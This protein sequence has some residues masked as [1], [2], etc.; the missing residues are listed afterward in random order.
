MTIH[1]GIDWSHQKHDVVIANE[2]GA[3]LSR[4]TIEHGAAGF[5]KL[6][7][8][9]ASLGV[10]AADCLVGIESSNNILL[11]FLQTHDYRQVYVVPPHLTAASRGRT[12]VN[13]AHTDQS[14]GQLI[15]ELLRTD[16]HRLQLWR[17]DS[18]LIQQIRHQVQWQHQ[19][20]QD[21]V[22]QENRLRDLLRRYYPAALNLFSDLTRQIT[23][24]FLVQYPDPQEAAALDYDAFA[25]FARKQGYPSP[26]SLPKQYARFQQPV[27]QATT[28]TILIHQTHGQAL[29]A[30]LLHLVKQRA[31]SQR[32]LTQLF[33]QHADASIFSSFPGLGPW[34]A[35]ALLSKF[36]DNRDRFP[37]PL[38]LQALAG[39]CPVTH[40]SGKSKRV[41]FRRACD[42]SFR[43]F[44]QQWARCSLKEST[45]A[46]SY[47]QE[48][49]RQDCSENDSYRRL[50]NRWLAVAWKCW[51]TATPYDEAYH[52]RQSVCFTTPTPSLSII[53]HS[54]YTHSLPV[55][56]GRLMYWI[57]SSC[58]HNESNSLA[59]CW[60]SFLP[61]LSFLVSYWT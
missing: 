15:T 50:A 59:T 51:Q 54:F 10:E 21:I 7:K 42:K 61:V 6:D 14:D 36:G 40:R 22:R 8:H 37:T 49:I 4:L 58:L 24:A 46:N 41:L 27:P 25:A 33:Q 43:Y 5:A 34:L 12:S 11:D 60:Y 30:E 47:F 17:P 53:Y 55:R 9:R 3:V 2:C 23:L 29:A 35:P 20:I 16:R 38:S 18:L 13:K 56:K 48:H 52:W 57:G 32:R 19:Q 1:I 31:Q 28:A 45:W 44:A 39:T 26:R